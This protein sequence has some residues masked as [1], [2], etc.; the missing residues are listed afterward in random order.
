MYK[1]TQ[2]VVGSNPT[3]GSSFFFED[4]CLG[5]CIVLLFLVFLV[6]LGLKSCIY[7]YHVYDVVYCRYVHMYAQMR[8]HKCTQTPIYALII[9]SLLFLYRKYEE[10][11]A[12]RYIMS[13][14]VSAYNIIQVLMF[15]LVDGVDTFA[16]PP[17][18]LTYTC[19]C[20]VGLR[21]LHHVVYSHHHQMQ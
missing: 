7:V 20:S 8:E 10:Q 6:S 16:P 18:A 9:V 5:I 13:F 2:K 11:S 19:I 1:C 17:L 21:S 15:I 4:D 12:N 14:T 3:Q